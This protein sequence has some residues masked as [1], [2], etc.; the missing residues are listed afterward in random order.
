MSDFIDYWDARRFTSSYLA[1]QKD[2]RVL[3]EEC[4][5]IVARLKKDCPV[6]NIDAIK[7]I[8]DDKNFSILADSI[9]EMIQKNQPEA[10]LDRLHTYVIKY[11]RKLCNRHGVSWDKNKPLHSIFGEYIKNIKEKNVIHSVMTERILKSSISVLE[12]FNDVRN[13]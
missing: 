10:A 5:K 4:L 1:Q 13:N 3:R 8:S 11:V 6:E 9:R 12:A 2:D 7:P